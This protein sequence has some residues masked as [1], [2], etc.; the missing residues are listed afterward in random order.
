MLPFFF[1]TRHF[2][3][4]AL[5]TMRDYS[6]QGRPMFLSFEARRDEV[7]RAGPVISHCCGG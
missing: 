7:L 4:A 6:E 2:V 3:E 1:E 5:F